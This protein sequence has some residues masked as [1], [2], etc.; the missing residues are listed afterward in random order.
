MFAWLIKE[1]QTFIQK[2][3]LILNTLFWTVDDFK[4]L[5]IKK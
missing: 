4:R 2:S 1:L 5:K 3:N